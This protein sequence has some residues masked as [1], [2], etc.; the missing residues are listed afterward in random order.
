MSFRGGRAAR[1]GRVPEVCAP[2]EESTIPRPVAGPRAGA[3]PRSPPGE[4]ACRAPASMGECRQGGKSP[5]RVSRFL[6][7]RQPSVHRA[8]SRGAPPSNDRC[9]GSS[10][11]GSGASTGRK[12]PPEL[13]EPSQALD[14]SAVGWHAHYQT[15]MRDSLRR[16]SPPMR[17]MR[18]NAG[19]FRATLF[20]INHAPFPTYHSRGCLNLV[21]CRTIVEQGA[22][23][24]LRPVV[25]HCNDLS[26]PSQVARGVP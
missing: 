7:R 20:A 1:C 4:R 12:T 8:R 18:S 19:V 3:G 22:R 25:L 14:R 17:Q 23:C 11:T 6:G 15:F 10:A 21:P 24:H 16:A 9:R 5:A 2:A 13:R 26:P